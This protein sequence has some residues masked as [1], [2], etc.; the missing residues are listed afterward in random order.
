M[1][2]TRMQH[3]HARISTVMGEHAELL[4]H[5]C[6]AIIPT[7]VCLLNSKGHVQDLVLNL[8]VA[9]FDTTAWSYL[10]L[11]ALLPQIP[12]RCTQRLREEQQ[13]VCPLQHG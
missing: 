5:L 11:A 8:L 6:A 10:V 13:Q 2:A 12:Q 1:P 7:A 9:G 4:V 3:E